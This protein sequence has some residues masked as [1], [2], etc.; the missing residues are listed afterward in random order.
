MNP[1]HRQQGRSVRFDWG[2]DGARALALGS[3]VAVVVD[4]LSFTTTVSVA[5]EAG[6]VVWPYRWDA[7]T[8]AGFA[9]VRGAV[10]AVG[11]SVAR[12]G[13][14]SLSPVSVANAPQVTRLVLPSP[15][16]STIAAELAAV[17]VEVVAASLRN[18]PAVARWL[19]EQRRGRVVALVAAGE[20]WGSGALRPAVEDLWGAGCV[21]AHLANF[22]WRGASVEAE[23]AAA[24]YRSVVDDIASEL[25]RCANG[26]ELVRGGYREDVLIAGELGGSEVVPRLTE[27]A[28]VGVG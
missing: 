5:V 21:A 8:A 2:L 15:N 9:R 20:R 23:V 19:D 14:V 22:G 26:Q 3:D 1:A 13:E 17:G 27:G 25:L 11:R 28:F 12:Q 16:G 18:G 24:A 7:D 6:M 4:V 10:L